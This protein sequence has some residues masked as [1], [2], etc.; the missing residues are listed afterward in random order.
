MTQVGYGEQ[1][2]PQSAIPNPKYKF[3]RLSR[4][5]MLHYDPGAKMMKFIASEKNIRP[6]ERKSNL[7]PDLF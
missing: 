6:A 5:S 3:V 4:S 2:N 7:E 1:S